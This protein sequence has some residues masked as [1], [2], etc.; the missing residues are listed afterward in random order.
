M[1]YD[2]CF[3]LEDVNAR[4]HNGGI[5]ID[6][7]QQQN[8]ALAC[9]ESGPFPHQECLGHAWKAAMSMFITSCQYPKLA[10]TLQWE[11][12]NFL[13]N[14]IGLS[15]IGLLEVCHTKS[16]LFWPTD[17]VLPFPEMAKIPKSDQSQTTSR[18]YKSEK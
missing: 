11:W 18:K 1:F 16:K 4:F 12:Q 14:D 6:Y 7:L 3:I 9:T 17:G 5:V 13:K 8:I 2:H 15:D 10:E